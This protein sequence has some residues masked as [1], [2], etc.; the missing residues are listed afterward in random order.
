M[1]RPSDHPYT[2][3]LCAR[4]AKPLGKV[5]YYILDSEKRFTG[6]LS[7]PKC[8]KPGEKRAE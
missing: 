8:S 1:T 5:S 3:V 4:C 2:E 7:C 6:Q